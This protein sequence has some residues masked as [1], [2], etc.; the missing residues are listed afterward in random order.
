MSRRLASR[1]TS[2]LA[3]RRARML[4]SSSRTLS[5]RKASGCLSIS[6]LRRSWEYSGLGRGRMRNRRADEGVASGS[7][8]LARMAYPLGVLLAPFVKAHVV[9]FWHLDI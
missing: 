2:R 9:D 6:G 4:T 3:G 1:R 7:Y 5:R 8:R